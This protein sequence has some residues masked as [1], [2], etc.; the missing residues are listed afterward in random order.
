MGGTHCLSSARL[1]L[2]PPLFPL[3]VREGFMEEGLATVALPR[4]PLA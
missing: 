4:F 1:R 3:E 2:P